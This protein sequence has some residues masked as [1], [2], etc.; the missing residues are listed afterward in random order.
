MLSRVSQSS[1]RPVMQKLSQAVFTVMASPWIG[2]K[3]LA[4]M[5]FQASITKCSALLHTTFVHVSGV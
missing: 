5:G 3:S 2:R 1:L 4:M